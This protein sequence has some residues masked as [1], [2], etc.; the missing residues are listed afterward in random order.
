MRSLGITSGCSAYDQQRANV[1]KHAVDNRPAVVSLF[2][3]LF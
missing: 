3:D 2:S 1:I